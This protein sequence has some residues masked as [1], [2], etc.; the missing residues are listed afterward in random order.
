MNY[1]PSSCSSALTHSTSSSNTDTSPSPSAAVCRALLLIQ[2]DDLSLKIEAAKEIRRLTKTSQRC[3]R[4]L[5]DAVKPLVCMLRVGDDDSVENE[6]ALL[7]LLNLAVKDETN[8]I[9]I[10]KAGALESIISFLQSQN[11]I[12]QEYAT[13][14]LLTLSASTNNKPVIGACGAIPL[15]V[16]ILR[17]GITQAKVD[18]VMALSNLSTHSDNL[19]IILKTNPIPS[20]VSLLKTCKKSTKTAEKCCALIESLVGFDE[21]RIALTS[22]EG[23]ILAVIEVLENGSLQSR[24][25]AVGALLTLCQSDRCKYREPILREGVIPGLLELTVQGTP[26]S[27]LKA[28]TLL[29]LLRDTP[30]PRSELQPDTLENI[31]CNIISQIDGDE[32]SGKAKKML[33]EMVQVSMEQ[34]LRHLQQRALVCTPTPNDLPISS[35]TSEVSSK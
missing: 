5:A 14:A 22:E 10:V 25:H 19:D 4:Q 2:S 7:A 15:L 20:I 17:N 28:Q 16:E 33:A 34:S 13:A 23:G 12:L 11:S 32:Q 6:S 30:Y 27:Q 9:S 31:V 8:K 35:C 3:R 18:A 26:K 24:E 21:G 29:R 1:P